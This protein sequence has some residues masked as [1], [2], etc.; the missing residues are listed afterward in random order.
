MKVYFGIDLAVSVFLCL[1]T[2]PLHR[3]FDNLHLVKLSI[4]FS[5]K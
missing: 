5:H 4:Y 1:E 3:T 2:L